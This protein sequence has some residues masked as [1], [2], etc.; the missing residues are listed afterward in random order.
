METL[1]NNHISFV[2]M[3]WR[4]S[5]SIR[6]GRKGEYLTECYK[7]KNIEDIQNM[8]ETNYEKPYC[9]IHNSSMEKHTSSSI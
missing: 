5:F 6:F 4:V 7:T 9:L 3:K 8:K 1:E 2:E